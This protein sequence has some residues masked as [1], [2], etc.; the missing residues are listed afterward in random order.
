MFGVWAARELE[1]IVVLGSLPG[2]V[3]SSWRL[4]VD[5]WGSRGSKACFAQDGGPVGNLGGSVPRGSEAEARLP[6][7]PTAWEILGLKAS[8]VQVGGRPK[9][10]K[11][12][13]H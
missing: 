13:V 4:V 5:A 7:I 3:G 10:S 6:G 1:P 2:C 11:G 8:I 9:E 12:S